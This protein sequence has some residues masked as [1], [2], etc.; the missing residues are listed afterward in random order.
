MNLRR[1]RYDAHNLNRFFRNPVTSHQKTMRVYSIW[2]TGN[3]GAKVFA[4][5]KG[6]LA[7]VLRLNNGNL[8]HLINKFLVKH[9]KDENVPFFNSVKVGK[10][11]SRGKPAVTGYN[12]MASF[13]AYRQG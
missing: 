10:K 5:F 2:G 1:I 3:Q 13:A 6:E 9:R 11:L 8:I 4:I 7:Y 12:T